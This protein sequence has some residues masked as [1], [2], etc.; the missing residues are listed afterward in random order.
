MTLDDFLK[1]SKT[2]RLVPL[3]HRSL[4]ETL[5]GKRIIEYENPAYAKVKER[6]ARVLNPNLSRFYGEE[7]VIHAPDGYHYGTFY[8]YDGNGFMLGNYHFENKPID[9]FDYAKKSFFSTDSFVPIQNII[10]ISKIPLK[11]DKK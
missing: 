1:D 9:T 11:V 8:G 6:L 2:K 5:K 10:S 7:V 3:S 4:T